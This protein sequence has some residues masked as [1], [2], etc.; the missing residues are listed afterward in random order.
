LDDFNRLYKEDPKRLNLRDNVKKWLPIHH[1]AFK[2][3]ENIIQFIID[4][5]KSNLH[6]L[7]TV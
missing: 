3:K 7:I 5:E 1:A 4:K 6:D 2:G